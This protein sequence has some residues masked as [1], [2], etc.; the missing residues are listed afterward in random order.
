MTVDILIVTIS[1]IASI[2]FFIFHI[3]VFRKMKKEA[4]FTGLIYVYLF[5]GIFACLLLSTGFSFLQNYSLVTDMMI[6]ILSFFLYTMTVFVYIL[7]IFGVLE[8]SIRMRLLHH[9]ADTGSKGVRLEDLKKLY[10]VDII[11]SKRLL[12]FSASGELILVGGR[13]QRN[14]RYS[15]IMLPALLEVLMMK[16]YT[17]SPKQSLSQGKRSKR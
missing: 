10:N 12:R 4:V 7:Y 8:S 16:L 1:G 17:V 13:Y 2:L 3:L 6:A 9:I 11:I 14:K 15:F 5:V